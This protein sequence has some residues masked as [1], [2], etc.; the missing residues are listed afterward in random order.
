MDK[1]A[2][3]E[4]KESAVHKL[5]KTLCTVH[6]L[7]QFGG[8]SYLLYLIL[9]LFIQKKAYVWD[10]LTYPDVYNA[11][12][13]AQYLQWFDLVFGLI[14]IT[15]TNAFLAFWQILGRCYVTSVIFGTLPTTPFGTSV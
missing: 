5:L 10:V 11:L 4:N 15:R 1:S 13:F 9:S 12:F 2:K 3:T 6:N 7:V 8:W 14:G